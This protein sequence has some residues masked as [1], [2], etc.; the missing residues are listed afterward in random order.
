MILIDCFIIPL[1]FKCVMS[2]CPRNGYCKPLQW[3]NEEL[4]LHVLQVT[5]KVFLE[6]KR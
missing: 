3:I 2:K 1:D 5:I 4:N 6:N